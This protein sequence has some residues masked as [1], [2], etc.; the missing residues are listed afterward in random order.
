MLVGSAVPRSW[1]FWATRS[2][3]TRTFVMPSLWSA[4][5]MAD[6]MCAVVR[7]A[8]LPWWGKVWPGSLM[9]SKCRSS[10]AMALRA[11]CSGIQITDNKRGSTSG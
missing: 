10:A 4:Q 8:A 2:S 9:G 1:L 3:P 6:R 7:P 11:A 5:L